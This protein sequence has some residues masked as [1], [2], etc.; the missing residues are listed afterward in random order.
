MSDNLDAVVETPSDSNGVEWG[1][2]DSEKTPEV[3][4]DYKL[5]ITKKVAAHPYN[6]KQKA[7]VYDAKLFFGDE[8]IGDFTDAIRD[9]VVKQAEVVKAVHD[10]ERNPEDE[11]IWL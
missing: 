10:T 5:V 3:E 7:I 2:P 9:D 1:G 11:V 8:Q 4:T 6:P